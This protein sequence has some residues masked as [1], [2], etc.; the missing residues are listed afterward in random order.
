MKISDSTACE[1]V[2]SSSQSPETAQAAMAVR[3]LVEA[4]NG[5]GIRYCHWKSN[6]K[7][8]EALRGDTDIDLLVDRSDAA[9]FQSLVA[10]F[11]YKP[12]VGD[13]SPSI[14]HY[15]GLDEADRGL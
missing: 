5:A 8:A 4:L 9:R 3:A 6:W 14:C 2:K 13:A 11:G 7:L 12:G 1:P 10:S 15:Y